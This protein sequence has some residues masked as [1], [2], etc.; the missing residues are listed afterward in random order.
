MKRGRTVTPAE[1]SKLKP[2]FMSQYEEYRDAVLS[3]KKPASLLEIEKVKRQERDL[4]SGKWS[5]DT[6]AAVRPLAWMAKNLAFPDGPKRGKPL[7]LE[8]WQVYDVMC[9]FGWLDQRGNR[10]YRDAYIAVPRKNG[11]STW[12]AAVIDYCTFCNEEDVGFPGYIAATSL[13]Q[14]GECFARAGSCLALAGHD[15]VQVQNSKNNKVVK[16][17]GQQIIAVSGDP[18]DGKLPAAVIIDEYHQH[19]SNDLVKSFTSGNVSNPNALTL[20][21]TTAGT[22]VY[23]V[24]KLEQD[25]CERVLEGTLD[26]PRYFV[27]IYCAD[28]EDSPD[29][30]LTWMKANPNWNVSVDPEAFRAEYDN[31]KCSETEMI[32]FKTKNLNMWCSSNTKWANM[33]KFLE[34]CTGW[35]ERRELEGQKC[36]G[37]LDLA[38]VSDFTAWCLDFPLEDGTHKQLWRYWVPGNRVMELERQLQIPLTQWIAEGFVRATPG[39]VIDYNIVAEDILEDMDAYDIAFI[40][41]D[42]WHMQYLLDKLPQKFE[43][44]CIEFSQGMKAMSPAVKEYEREYLCGAIQTGGNP[45]QTWMMSCVEARQDENGN[46]KLVK[47]QL[48]KSA[49]R[50]DGVIA[51]VMANDTAITYTETKEKSTDVDDYIAFF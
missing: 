24:C 3:G 15:G 13:D 25:K 29:D 50:I 33:P 45:V 51:A 39:E 21:I 36:Y 14:A 38:A 48:K 2:Y 34:L 4:A 6:D 20:R 17:S 1:L 18:K 47:P 37:G 8:S 35:F 12:A 49:S 11:K 43:D 5:W 22:N 32:A 44:I 30:E 27:S 19:L 7:K 16:W 26:I 40:A 41:V 31:A 23:S 46:V 10:R 9:L 28:K 42:K